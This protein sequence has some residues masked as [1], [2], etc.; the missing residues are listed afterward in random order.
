MRLPPNRVWRDQCDEAL[1]FLRAHPGCT[2]EEVGDAIYPWE[3]AS[4]S[5]REAFAARRLETLR[6]RGEAWKAREGAR[7]R[8]TAAADAS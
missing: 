4:A 8:W 2:A 7:W 6:D 5:A 1:E 3:G